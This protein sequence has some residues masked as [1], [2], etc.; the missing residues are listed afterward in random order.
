MA[1]ESTGVTELDAADA[2]PV[3]TLFVAVTVNVYGVPLV[4][5]ETVI[6]EAVPVPVWLPVLE[7]TV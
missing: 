2:L 7:V 6:G 3:P 5:P 4:R 1:E